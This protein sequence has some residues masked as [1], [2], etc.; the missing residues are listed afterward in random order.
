M[1]EQQE[2]TSEVSDESQR[3]IGWD[4]FAAVRLVVGE[5]VEAHPVAKSNKLLRLIVNLGEDFGTRQILAGI[6][7]SYQT[8]DLVQRK[9]VVVANLKPAKLMG[10][11]S[12]GM[13]LASSKEDR[14]ILIDPG[15]DAVV[16]E[17]V[18]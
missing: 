12:Q 4:E 2:S 10:L 9:I 11:E 1:N 8:E 18:R 16:G 5:V 13:L 7:K 3:L 14:V 6:A 15:T 17:V